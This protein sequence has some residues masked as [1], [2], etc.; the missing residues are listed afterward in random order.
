MGF[1]WH[2]FVPSQIPNV[3]CLLLYVSRKPH[4]TYYAIKGRT[5]DQKLQLHGNLSICTYVRSM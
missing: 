2:I 4:F 3:H 1:S 5:V